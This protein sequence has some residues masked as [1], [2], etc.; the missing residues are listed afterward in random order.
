MKKS[1][2][3]EKR[4]NIRVSNE[5][6]DILSSK[7]KSAHVSVST[8]LREVGLKGEI[9]YLNNGKEI[10]RQIGTLH[11]KIEMY[12]QDMTDKIDEVRTTLEES[13][14]FLRDSWGYNSTNLKTALSYQ[15]IKI[16]T[17]LNMLK[18]SYE[19]H[20]KDIE[21]QLKKFFPA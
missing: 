14:R 19:E 13:N 12:H 10:A 8:F 11:G 9:T 15:Q 5:E 4:I 3:K 1:N 20:E 7:A 16:D 17:I 18:H 6:Y 2:I 21:L